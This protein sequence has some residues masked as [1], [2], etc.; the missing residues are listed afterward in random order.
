MKTIVH[1]DNNRKI[2]LTCDASEYGVGAVL[3][4]IMDDGSEK[5]IAMGSRTLSKRNYAQIDREAAA[6][7]FGLDKFN[8]YVYGRHVVIYTDHKPLLG[9]FSPN[10]AIPKVL[11]PRMMR[12]ALKLNSHDYDLIYKCGTSIGNARSR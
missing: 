3:S 11:S 8:Q 9:I 6:I 5:P 2:T 10:K 1:F 7:M 4:H 12:W